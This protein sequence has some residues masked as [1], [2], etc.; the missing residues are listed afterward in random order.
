MEDQA[1]RSASVTALAEALSMV[2]GATERMGALWR[3]E[4]LAEEA[5]QSQHDLSAAVRE[6]GVGVQ[7]LYEVATVEPV[8]TDRR[9]EALGRIVRWAE[10]AVQL[11]S[12]ADIPI[13]ERC[14]T[15]AALHVALA[16]AAP[17]RGA[18]IDQLSVPESYIKRASQIVGW[19]ERAWL[20]ADVRQHSKARGAASTACQC[21]LPALLSALKSQ[22]SA[23]AFRVLE[24]V[25]L[26]VFR[27]CDGDVIPADRNYAAVSSLFM[28]RAEQSATFV[29]RKRYGHAAT[30]ER[31]NSAIEWTEQAERWALQSDTFNAKL[32]RSIYA[33]RV[34]CEEAC[35]ST[36]HSQSRERT[37]HLDVAMAMS[38]K[39][40]NPSRA[41]ENPALLLTMTNVCVM[42]AAQYPEASLKSKQL[43]E[44]SVEWSTRAWKSREISWAS[45]S[46]A[47]ACAILSLCSLATLE[48]DMRRRVSLYEEG[49][50][51]VRLACEEAESRAPSMAYQFKVNGC[52]ILGHWGHDLVRNGLLQ[53]A[54]ELWASAS[55]WLAETRSLVD[56]GRQVPFGLEVVSLEVLASPL[57]AGLLLG[58]RWRE[59]EEAIDNVL[60]ISVAFIPQGHS[61]TIAG[62]A[63]EV[64]RWAERFPDTLE[65]HWKHVESG[66]AGATE[67]SS[68]GYSRASLVIVLAT[69]I[70]LMRRVGSSP[71]P[72]Q[73]SQAL[74]VSFDRVIAVLCSAQRAL[75][76]SEFR[77]YCGDLIRE[78]FA[79][80]LEVAWSLPDHVEE[81]DVVERMLLAQSMSDLSMRLGEEA[82]TTRT[83]VTSGRIEG[84][85]HLT[86]VAHI[87][88]SEGRSYVCF[89]DTSFRLLRAVVEDDGGVL[90]TEIGGN[91]GGPGGT[92]PRSSGP[93][94]RALALEEYQRYRD[95]VDNLGRV[96]VSGREID[97]GPGLESCLVAMADRLL[98]G[99]EGTKVT[100]IPHGF[101]HDVLCGSAWAWADR[102]LMSVDQVP[103]VGVHLSL[104]ASGRARRAREER[105][106][107]LLVLVRD[108]AAYYEDVQAE[109]VS[110]LQA[111]AEIYRYSVDRWDGPDGIG[112]FEQDVEVYRDG[113]WRPV[114]TDRILPRV[115][116][117]LTHGSF[118]DAADAVLLKSRLSLTSD[119]PE[120]WFHLDPVSGAD[121][122]CIYLPVA[123][124]DV[125]T[126]GAGV[127]TEGFCVD[128]SR[129]SIVLSG[130]CGGGRIS[131]SLGEE[132]A[133]LA[134]LFLV[135]GVPA[136]VASAWPVVVAQRSS[137]GPGPLVSL[138]GSLLQSLVSGM[139]VG[140]SVRAARR[141]ARARAQ[142]VGVSSADTQ[143]L[144][145]EWGHLMLL[146]CG[147]TPSP[148]GVHP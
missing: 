83:A 147:D 54:D 44:L 72:L 71:R 140:S 64:V 74:L 95:I 96:E 66:H 107:V 100:L 111:A 26:W 89:F 90:V 112:T 129:C 77:L 33:I 103:S 109:I 131:D 99:V 73:P 144:F 87:A 78:V 85:A 1:A 42:L 88:R 114:P 34:Q 53:E 148:W 46:A 35:A 82:A 3:A 142:A 121:E 143:A 63:A 58:G 80:S 75:P 15:G 141:T 132:G 51:W 115:C 10:R 43:M 98:D 106:V 81:E 86:E 11:R 118:Q 126:H 117:W 22:D 25:R 91:E 16:L 37:A 28:A 70:K 110:R 146:G 36:F 5:W 52:M 19:A 97:S 60:R 24:S 12:A 45:A 4:Q 134:R 69:A 102:R 135:A 116:V 68:A 2:A 59:F 122:H 84:F 13:V 62:V 125:A 76:A 57:L 41:D 101:S 30:R 104:R 61:T 48:S 50:G 139:D 49:L 31:L 40:F 56:S 113:R 55:A 124:A 20:S 127:N 94:C 47:A 93:E 6:I 92:E 14:L 65:R 120:A 123:S 137:G 18:W 21:C 105:P 17:D 39:A 136:V 67:N 23:A 130:A 138:W 8:A 9:E 32:L 27:T 7:A 145:V 119:A 79:A 133:G 38:E 128:L 29:F 108:F